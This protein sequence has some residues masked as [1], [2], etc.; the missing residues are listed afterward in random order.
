MDFLLDL[1]FN[2]L[3]LILIFFGIPVASIVVFIVCLVKYCS[4]MRRKK[5]APE[6]VSAYRLRKLI[7]TG[8]AA[9]ILAAVSITLT[10]VLLYGMSHM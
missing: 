6:S 2:P 4:A 7:I 10:I 8:A 5:W 3:I 9:F 1:L